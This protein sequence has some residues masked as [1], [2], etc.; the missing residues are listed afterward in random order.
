MSIYKGNITLTKVTNGSDGKTYYTYIRYADNEKGDNISD[1]PEGKNYMGIASNIQDSIAPSDP[2]KYTWSL[3]KG[4][5]G[6]PALE[7]YLEASNTEILKFKSKESTENIRLSPQNLK[8]YLY[9]TSS[10]NNSELQNINKENLSIFYSSNNDFVEIKEDCIT[11]ED[12]SLILNLNEIADK[13]DSESGLI[14]FVYKIKENNNLMYEIYLVIPYRYGVNPDMAN[15]GVYADE[16]FASV[17]NSTLSFS[18]D[19]LEIKNGGLKVLTTIQEKE[20]QV[21]YFDDTTGKLKISGDLDAAGGTF[22][23]ELV[24][25]SGRFAGDIS[26]ATGKIGGFTI[27]SNQLY[28]PIYLG[29]EEDP[30]NSILRL[31]GENGEIFAQNITLGEGAKIK[32]YLNL[33]ENEQVKI[34]NPD[35][36]S[37][38]FLSV[39]NG[40]QTTVQMTQNGEI[41][42]GS[43]KNLITFDGKTGIIQTSNFNNGLGWKISP[44]ESVF[45]DVVV[46][47]SIKASVLEYGEVQ[48]VGGI[49]I[50]RPSS[51]IK[52]IQIIAENGENNENIENSESKENSENK[53][54][55]TIEDATGF[56]I[57][58][59]CLI[60]EN[61]GSSKL[62]FLIDRVENNDIYVTINKTTLDTGVDFNKYVG[63]PL[64]DMGVE[65]NNRNIG[66]GLNSSTNNSLVEANSLSVFE[67][68]SENKQLNTKIILGQIPNNEGLYGNMAG[69]YGLYAENVLLS[70]SLVT[71]FEEEGGSIT[72]YYSGISSAYDNLSGEY[73]VSSEKL[74]PNDENGCGGSSEILLWAGAP[75]TSASDVEK[76]KFYVDRNGN[77][78]ANSGRFEGSIITDSIIEAG[79][80]KTAK[81]TG[82]GTKDYGLVFQDVSNG[83]RFQKSTKNEQDQIVYIDLFTLN[84]SGITG[85]GTFTYNE[86]KFVIDKDGYVSAPKFTTIYKETN[87]ETEE[88]ITKKIII[89]GYKIY[90]ELNSVQ[91]FTLN[92]IDKSLE[93]KTGSKDNST[94][95]KIDPQ[96]NISQAIMKF[97][98]EV[99]YG[100][101]ASYKPAYNEKGNVVIG[102]DLYIKE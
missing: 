95:F 14:K 45:N 46:R 39:K 99:E 32:T 38:V 86:D 73:A 1:N 22:S 19:G 56:Q 49:L 64:I 101:K 11:K 69:T 12:K 83:I 15:L 50:I 31:N 65:T 9:K 20:K 100:N 96:R 6:E 74:F 8:L 35:A 63:V 47:G 90:S 5:K 21:L 30:A 34:F 4:D 93:F 94:N 37:G 91:A 43:N 55:F 71:S 61:Q 13:I 80:I 18:A 68:D 7:Y 67:F 28:T 42:L 78:Y 88:E 24:A 79:E 40:E 16:I 48:S 52:N 3:I 70:G 54:I 84:S 82:N 41:K 76:S 29:E 26:A 59:Y 92:F 27:A 72:K 17:N 77:L 10:Q 98:N 36:N 23:G 81:I 60:T 57:G 102:Y 66:L 87:S 25:A 89:D 2:G 58:D 44:T 33:G 51:I 62:Y 75:G 53:I 85:S 97:E